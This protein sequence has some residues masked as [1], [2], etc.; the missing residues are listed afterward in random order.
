MNHKFRTTLALL[1]GLAVGLQAQDNNR[2]T[3]FQTLD[4]E[5]RLAFLQNQS[6]P[7]EDDFLRQALDLTDSARIE[8]GPEN[9]LVLKRT[10]AI[11]IIRLLSERPV[12]ASAGAIARIP[13]QYKDPVLRGEAWLAL[14]KLGERPLIPSLVRSLN[15]LNES[16]QRT[17]NEEIQANYLIQAFG[18]FKAPEA[19]RAVVGATLGWYSPASQ[20]KPL[21]RKTLPLLVPDYEAAVL[22]LLTNDD[23]L[24]LREGL[25]LAVVDQ[26]NAE[27]SGRAAAAVLQTLVRL[28]AADK[29]DQDRTERLILAALLAAQK[30]PSP[31]DSLVPS[32]KVLVTRS[33]SYQEVIQS[34]QLL[35]KIDDPAALAFLSSTLTG[36]NTRQ[37]S[38]TNKNSDLAVV[39]EL[40]LALGQ[41]GKASARIP[42]NDARFSDYTPALVREAQDALD[43]LPRE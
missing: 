21:A 2:W 43:K 17:R 8:S 32:L 14:A 24:T 31:Q 3:L 34:V 26:G 27:F 40:F 42:L 29:T 6:T 37:K 16:G 41:T 25:F 23:D 15:T 28:Q 9:E 13:T 38:G 4:W 30:S 22:N 5:G 7:L 11:Q 19:F 39:R 12:P 35:G 18:I 33:S 36:F 10:I 1:L 20:V